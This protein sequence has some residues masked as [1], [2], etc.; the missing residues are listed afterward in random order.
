MAIDFTDMTP[1]EILA[2]IEAGRKEVEVRQTR[3]AL[4]RDIN[5]VL[6]QAREHGAAH[7]PQREW[8]GTPHID[9]SF[10]LGETTVHDGVE[11]VSRIPNNTCHPA[12]CRTG[13][14]RVEPGDDG[15]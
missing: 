8:T 1:E 13:W 12:E 4:Q 3:D 15:A 10:A 11:Y 6:V 14:E 7:Q 2:L 5:Q 9:E